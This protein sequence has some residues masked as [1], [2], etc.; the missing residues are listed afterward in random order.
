MADQGRL[1]P[2]EVDLVLDAYRKCTDSNESNRV[3]EKM[4]ITMQTRYGL[5]PSDKL[6]LL[7]LRG[8]AYNF[9]P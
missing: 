3:A 8:R 5:R 4:F 7:W 6:S 9:F 2:D 1:S